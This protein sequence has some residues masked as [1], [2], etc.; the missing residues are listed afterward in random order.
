[1]SGSAAQLTAWNLALR[2]A[3][4]LVDH[5]RDDFLARAGRSEDQHRDVG[6][7]GGA[8]PLEDDQHLL[9]AADHLAEPLHRRRLVL[10]AD[11]RASLEEVVE[12]VGE[13]RVGGP[14]GAVLRRVVPAIAAATPKSTSSRTQFST[15]SRR[16]PNVCISDS[17][18]KASS[19][20]E[21]R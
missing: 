16:R 18:S 19:G 17:T 8:D 7:G 5:S 9:V 1:M 15:S 10:G 3:A 6:L 20:R 2:A 4:Q 21:F 12:Q 13:R 11:R 14:L